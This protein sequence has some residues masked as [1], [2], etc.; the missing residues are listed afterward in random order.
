MPVWLTRIVVRVRALI[1]RGHDRE[2]DAEQHLHLELLEEEYRDRGLSPDDARLQAR[3]DFGNAALLKET[4]R[5]QFS[6]RIVE[7][8]VQDLRYAFRSLLADR[9]FSLATIGTLAVALSLVTVVFAIFNA[10][11]L[12]P[13]AVHDPYSLHEIRWQSQDAG[14]RTFR[15]R[16]YQELLTRTELFESVFAERNRSVSSGDLPL[17]AAFVSGNYFDSLGGRIAL[18]RGLAEFDARTPGAAA[19][20]VLSDDAWRRLYDRDPAILGRELP[21]NNQTFVIVG[22]AHRDFI[23][24]N[25]SPPDV[26]VPVTMHAQVM[27]QDLFA[28]EQP[29]ELA[30]IARLRRGVTAAQAEDALGAFITRVMEQVKPTRAQ[31]LLQATPAPLTLELLLVLSPVFA[32]FGLVLVAACA[33]VSNLMLARGQARYRDTGVRL[34][35]GA[36]RGRVV[37]QMLTEGILLAAIAGVAA[38]GLASLVL[39]AG[40]TILFRTLPASSASMTRVVPLALDHRV[41]A[42]TFLVAAIATVMFALLPALQSTKLSLTHALRG[43]VRPGVRGSTLRSVLVVG[44]VAVSLMLLIGAATIL[45]N[46]TLAASA[47]LG[48]DTDGLITVQRLTVPRSVIPGAADALSADPAVESVAVASHTP[49]SGQGPR[50]P[51]QPAGQKHITGMSLLYAS[52][53]YF[54]LLGVDLSRGRLFS[55]DEARAEAPVGV[56][57]AA[58]AAALWPG[59]EPLGQ[60]VR[61][62]LEPEERPDLTMK[63]RLVSDTDIARLGLDVVI[64]GVVEDVVSGFIYEGKTAKLYLPTSPG[65]SKAST[66]IARMRS[67]QDVGPEALQKLFTRTGISPIA[68]EAYPLDEALALQLYPL[69]VSSWIGMVLSGIALGLSVS[70]IFG[71]VAYALSRRTREIGIRTA[72]G[73]TPGGIVRLMMQQSSKLV[74]AG[75]VAGFLIAFTVLAALRAVV[76]LPGL[77]LLDPIAFVASVGIV[78]GA[79]AIAAFLPA[80]RAGRVDPVQAL[81]ADG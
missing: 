17:L 71:V 56:I 63:R 72:L 50:A 52:P 74:V 18:G 23:G 44:Q 42:F 80:R 6:F 75:A 81:R 8:F 58:G 57:S 31:V 3:R 62:W 25:D 73:A 14:G 79:A 40:V 45:R 26:W 48:V 32:A 38:L 19:V 60:V 39:R 20:A 5:E 1:S 54:P 78:A 67:S 69:R 30:V 37:R 51:L 46:S 11:V 66:I 15:W 43:E 22:V 10:Y 47:P 64:V 12:R 49:L 29:R 65:G 7:Q 13:Y 59:E 21:I 33:N 35:L 9:A 53:E 4:S 16:D 61:V 77:T 55:A 70:G 41:F 34:S 24:L 68:F 27:T 76:T 2:L 28:G 36:S